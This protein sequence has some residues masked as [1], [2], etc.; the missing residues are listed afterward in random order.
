MSLLGD[1]IRNWAQ[2]VRLPNTLTAASDV[3]AGYCILSGGFSIPWYQSV[4][5]ISLGAVASISFYWAGMI[6]N[7]VFDVEEDRARGRRG[8]LVSGKISIATA[9]LVGRLLLVLGMILP[10]VAVW[11]IRSG[12]ALFSFFLVGFTAVVLASSILWYD[13]RWKSSRI[14]PLLMG[15]C[16]SLNMLLGAS[17]GA[18]M[19]EEGLHVSV[20]AA[21]YQAL[22]P[23]V[24]GHGLFVIGIT[25]A[26]RREEFADQSRTKLMIAWGTSVL[27]VVFIAMCSTWHMARPLRLDAWTFFPL[28]IGVLALPWLRRAASS[29][30][31][32][33]ARTLVPAIKQAIIS[34]LFFDAAIS[35][36][37]GGD[38]MG[39]LVCLMAVPTFLMSRFF[40]MT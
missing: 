38:M 35:L 7:D 37:F 26:A 17:L 19:L 27:G 14:G 11:M 23:A 15:L 12:N 21:L 18:A 28:L 34:I 1:R 39:T 20:H 33:S 22:F 32:L 29:I 6:L 30:H 36:Q 9:R 2:L 4:P 40:R 31:D 24:I 3:F 5:F 16:R 25:L 13:S 8:P 10:L